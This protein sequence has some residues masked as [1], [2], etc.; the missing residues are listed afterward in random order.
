MRPYESV[1]EANVADEPSSP[2]RLHQRIE[3]RRCLDLAAEICLPE[4]LDVLAAKLSGLPGAE[5]AAALEITPA[6]VDHRY[7]NAVERLRRKLEVSRKGVRH[8]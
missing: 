4:E 1:E 3:F 6:V 2:E 7:R 8:A 5:I